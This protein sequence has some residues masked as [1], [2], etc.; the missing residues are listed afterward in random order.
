M[1]VLKLSKQ[2]IS[3]SR[4]EAEAYCG[5]KGKLYGNL[6]LMDSKS[7]KLLE[8][9][10]YT[11][12]FGEL[13]FIVTS[14]PSASNLL[15]HIKGSYRLSF[16][17]IDTELKSH[18][19]RLTK[20]IPHKVDLE[21]PKTNLLFQKSGDKTFC[22]INPV[23]NRQKFEL[24]KAHLRPQLHP[25]SMHPRLCRAFVNLTGIKKGS[26]FDPFCGTGGILIE[27]GLRGIKPIGSDISDWMLKKAKINCAHY[28]V[29]TKLEKK[30]A[31]SIKKK[32]KYIVTDLAYGK[33]TASGKDL[34]TKFF[35]HLPKI[36]GF[37]A[38]IGVPASF[39]EKKVMSKLPE[40]NVV[41]KFTYYLHKS[42]SKK[43]LVIEKI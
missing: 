1:L 8:I 31:L 27:A 30:D 38:V 16:S 23:E 28:G 2:D 21:N 24:R 39:D 40:L 9:L 29:E 22:I 43:I 14:K 37:K 5:H 13:G 10:A 25:S 18:L 35:I 19:L 20:E 32:Y 33:N 26:V 6:L 11:K 15:R 41:D 7:K 12:S 36:L 3:L 17:G 42:L 34:I 4:A